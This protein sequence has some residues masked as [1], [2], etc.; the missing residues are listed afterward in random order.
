MVPPRSIPIRLETYARDRCR[1]QSGEGLSHRRNQGHQQRP[2]RPTLRGPRSGK[3]SF[4]SV[5]VHVDDGDAIETRGSQEVSDNTRAD[6]LSPACPP[7]LARVPEIGYDSDL[8]PIRRV[9][10]SRPETRAPGDGSPR[11]VRWA[12]RGRRRGPA[13]SHGARRGA[14]HRQRSPGYSAEVGYRV[15]AQ[16]PLREPG[17]PVPSISTAS[18]W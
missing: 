6:G 4:E 7:I 11:E 16:S 18:L 10:T 3:E 1:P 17:S 15:D 14:P 2:G 9:G 12:G 5:G 13:R 8:S